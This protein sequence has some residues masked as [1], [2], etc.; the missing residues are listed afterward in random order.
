MLCFKRIFFFFTMTIL[1]LEISFWKTSYVNCQNTVSTA[2]TGQKYFENYTPKE[3]QGHNQNWAVLQDKRGIIY[4]ANNSG[5]KE[6]DGL[7]WRQIDVS[8]QTVRSLAIDEID[9]IYVGGKDEIGY[10]APNAKGTLQ[11]VS[12]LK[13]LDT[14]KRSFSDAWETHCTKHGIYFR[15]P[16]FLFRLN[17]NSKK[18][19]VW[20]SGNTFHVSFIC[21]GTLFL[22]QKNVG[23]ME[24]D[25][26][27]D[28][29][30]LVPG[31][32]TFAN[33]K[34]YMM[35]PFEKNALLIGT[36][37]IGFYTYDI[38][39]GIEAMPF[40]TETDNYLKEKE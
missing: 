27:S 39:N 32:E 20:E 2:S 18:I 8:N 33:K 22:D 36:R 30:K 38:H 25:K 21:G 17:P 23:L 29:L 28:E 19:K 5:I 4:V 14:N 12:L 6:F 16:K 10:L 31:G 37:E 35:A 26:V 3:Y 34:I 7:S 40:P 13:Y 11:Y 9:T 1:L 15:T 24:M